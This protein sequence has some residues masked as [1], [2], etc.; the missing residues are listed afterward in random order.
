MISV[1]K[2]QGVGLVKETQIS[3]GKPTQTVVKHMES[4]HADKSRKS[5][6]NAHE[7]SL[8]LLVGAAIPSWALGSDFRAP[9]SES[10]RPQAKQINLR[11]FFFRLAARLFLLAFLFPQP[12]TN[13]FVTSSRPTKVAPPNLPKKSMPLWRSLRLQIWAAMH[14]PEVR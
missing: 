8:T 2:V 13:S 1:W 11:D 4:R 10:Q 5:Q 12:T 6:G 14:S 7:N 9:S 3:Q